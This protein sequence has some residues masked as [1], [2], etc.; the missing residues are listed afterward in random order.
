VRAG[1]AGGC[2]S[3]PPAGRS[4]TP[5]EPARPRV[6]DGARGRSIFPTLGRCTPACTSLRVAPAEGG[7]RSTSGGASLLG[8]P[9]R[10]GAVGGERRASGATRRSCRGGMRAPPRHTY[11]RRSWSRS[12]L[13]AV[14]IGCTGGRGRISTRRPRCDHAAATS[15]RDAGL[16]RAGR[17]RSPDIRSQ[18]FDFRGAPATR[19]TLTEMAHVNDDV[20]HRRVDGPAARPTGP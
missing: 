11:P 5:G 15:A 17:R 6:P 12:R 20:G 3:M 16:A 1:A 18:L 4:A 8:P 7:P 10:D 14:A 13:E 19:A 2:A 9:P